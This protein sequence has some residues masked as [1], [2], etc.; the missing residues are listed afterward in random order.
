MTRQL[1]I[2][3]VCCFKNVFGCFSEKQRLTKKEIMIGL[4]VP[5]TITIIGIMIYVL[6]WK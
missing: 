2:V 3:L 5:I 6:F 1:S 4:L